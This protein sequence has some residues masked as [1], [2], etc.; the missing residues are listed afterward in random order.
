MVLWGISIASALVWPWGQCMGLG[1]CIA[2]G[3]HFHDAWLIGAS[4]L[5]RPWGGCIV[6]LITY[7]VL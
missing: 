1:P 2:G 5:V 3:H 6:V 4:A 7:M